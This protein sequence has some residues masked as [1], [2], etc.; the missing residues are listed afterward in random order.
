MADIAKTTRPMT[1]TQFM[2]KT[3]EYINQEELV[4]TLFKDQIL[5]DQAREEGKKASTAPKQEED[6]NP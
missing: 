1:L 4:G 5:E 2:K 6:K 3:K